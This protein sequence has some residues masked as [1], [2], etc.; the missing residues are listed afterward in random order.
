MAKYKEMTDKAVN[1][2]KMEYPSLVK[3]KYKIAIIIYNNKDN[4]PEN[5]TVVDLINGMSIIINMLLKKARQ[6]KK[7]G[8]KW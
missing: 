3:Y 1:Y 6:S 7:G 5:V 8:A 4:F 2:M